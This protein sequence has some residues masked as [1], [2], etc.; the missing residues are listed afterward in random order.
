MVVIGWLSAFGWAIR[1]MPQ[2]LDWADIGTDPTTEH[3][4]ATFL[5]PNF[6]GTGSRI[7]ES[8]AYLLVAVLIAFVMWRA[9]RTVKRQLELDEEQRTLTDIFGRYVPKTIASALIS[10]E[11]CWNRS[12]ARR[13]SCS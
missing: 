6:V 8:V 1:D 12:R 13:L 11:A 7:Q 10:T 3:F 2:R 9:R 5:N 4:L